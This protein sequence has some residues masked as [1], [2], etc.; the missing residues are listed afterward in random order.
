[1]SAMWLAWLLIGA[2]AAT[3]PVPLER[4]RRAF[5]EVRI[6]SEEDGGRLWGKPLYGPMLFV[7]PESR[8]VVANRADEGGLLVPA[9]GLFIATLPPTIPVANTAVRW[10]GVEWTMIMWNSVGERTVSRRR[11]LLHESFHRIQD[12]IGFPMEPADN[13]HLDTLDGRYWLILEMRAL[14]AALRNENRD[15]AMSD[16]L[17]FRARRRAL[18]SNAAAN[19]RALENNEGLAEYT[20]F[21]LRGTSDE[22]TRLAVARWRLDGAG[23]SGTFVR[24]FAYSTGPA[25]GLLLDE[26]APEWRA[27]YKA[28]D[29]LAAVA[30]AATKLAVPTDLDARTAAYDGSRLR[31][32]EERRAKEQSERL[33]R[34]RAR[35]VDG[36]LLIIPTAIGSFGFDPNSVLPFGEH[37]TVHPHLTVTGDWGE[38]T[39]ESGARVTADSSLIVFSAEDRPRLNLKAGWV[40]RDGERQG[41]LVLGKA[42]GR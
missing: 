22:E 26:I 23:E 11:L 38:I 4:A 6:A 42:Q 33:A 15:V 20:G 32:D 5:D 18:F 3:S 24:S 9:D 19:E 2:S 37:G 28:T 36:P 30:A 16:A 21:A 10:S 12:D 27:R 17:G 41:D 39:T 35:L 40:L 13:A 7:D 25:W 1:M 34:Y 8:A 14:A 31:A 29:D